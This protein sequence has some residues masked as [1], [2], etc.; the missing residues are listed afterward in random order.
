MP[1]RSGN[2]ARRA[3]SRE[4]NEQ[5]R[6]EEAR[7][8]PLGWAADRVGAHALLRRAQDGLHFVAGRVR[9]GLRLLRHGAGDNA[10]FF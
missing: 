1:V 4:A 2:G 8:P 7:L 5:G 6:D 3:D 10:C 9:H